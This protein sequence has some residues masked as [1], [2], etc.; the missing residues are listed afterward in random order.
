MREQKCLSINHALA[1]AFFLRL[2]NDPDSCMQDFGNASQGTEGGALVAG[3]LQPADL[4]LGSLQKLRQILLGKP[5][6]LPERGDL[7]RH[8]PGLSGA[9][10]TGG[11]LRIP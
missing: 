4:L 6:L 9:L 5:G 2:E 8:I 11:E 10:K 3:R 7:Q 1:G